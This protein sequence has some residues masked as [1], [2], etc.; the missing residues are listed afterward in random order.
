MEAEGN[1][2]L[3]SFLINLAK[4]GKQEYEVDPAR[5]E[6]EY[7]KHLTSADWYMRKVAVY[8]LLFSLKLK[9]TEYRNYA[10]TRVLD[11]REDF[12]VRLWSG[13]GLSS[14]YESTQDVELLEVLT[15]ASHARDEDDVLKSSFLKDALQIFGVSSR[16][17]AFRL[18]SLDA[19]LIEIQSTFNEELKEIERLIS[20]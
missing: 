2:E 5:Y 13:S 10:I 11:R 18:K 12:E 8:C 3:G 4:W 16:D 19:R 9:K 1:D 7:A 6:A 14:A 15:L 20:K 17:Q